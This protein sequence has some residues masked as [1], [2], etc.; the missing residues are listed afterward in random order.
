MTRFLLGLALS[1]L[2]T[3]CAR[4][5]CTNGPHVEA[6]RAQ[7]R[8]G[9]APELRDDPPGAF[10]EA[11][12]VDPGDARSIALCTDDPAEAD[13]WARAANAKLY[14]TAWSAPRKV[15]RYVETSESFDFPDG[16]V[17]RWRVHKCN[18]FDPSPRGD[19]GGEGEFLGTLTTRP[20]VATTAYV[21][22]VRS[23]RRSPH[24]G[25]DI[26]SCAASEE[27]ERWVQTCEVIVQEGGGGDFAPEYRFERVVVSVDRRTGEMR[28]V[29]G[30]ILAREVA[31]CG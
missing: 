4:E 1:A 10:V 25:A 30:E 2:V 28:R 18:F 14:T 31:K 23:F 29:R 22:M 13:R 15:D 9:G 3:G 7:V 16:D 20:L 6:Y 19:R 11:R 24:L 21:T 5:E 8:A 12:D 27:P 17:V 26:V